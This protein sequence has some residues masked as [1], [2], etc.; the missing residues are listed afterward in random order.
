MTY[1]DLVT[2]ATVFPLTLCRSRLSVY[3]KKTPFHCLSVGLTWQVEAPG[4]G[5]QQQQQQWQTHPTHY[6]ILLLSY[7]KYEEALFT[8]TRD[9]ASI[10]YNH[11]SHSLKGSFSA[12]DK[13]RVCWFT[14]ASSWGGGWKCDRR[15]SCGSWWPG[16]AGGRSTCGRSPKVKNYN[17]H[18]KTVILILQQRD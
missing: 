13:R 3:F 12:E 7:L 16:G 17:F 14:S 9:Q 18:T 1:F 8:I 4:I 11:T 15:P 5:C 2:H 6:N 10:Y